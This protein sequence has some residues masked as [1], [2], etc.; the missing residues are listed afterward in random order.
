MQVGKV[1]PQPALI[2]VPPV[3]VLLVKP[4]VVEDLEQDS[5]ARPQRAVDPS[6][7]VSGLLRTQHGKLAVDVDGRVEA[8]PVEIHLAHVAEGK[9]AGEA[10]AYLPCVSDRRRAEVDAGDCQAV[11]GE[12]PG[13]Q[14]RSTGD[15]QEVIARLQAQ[16]FGHFL[17]LG[18]DF[19]VWAARRAMVLI[20]MLA[21][22]ALAEGRRRSR[23]DCPRRA[24]AP[25]AGGVHRSAAGQM[26]EARAPFAGA[27]HGCHVRRSLIGHAY[28]SPF[29]HLNRE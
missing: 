7:H 15:V 9:F 19:L 12:L 16:P 4:F 24:R 29:Y 27:P 8:P 2:C 1:A 11:P 25:P 14:A 3:A 26:P 6:Q 23:A 10:G 22:H 13:I 18:A 28:V 20:E 21:Q 5:P 17:H